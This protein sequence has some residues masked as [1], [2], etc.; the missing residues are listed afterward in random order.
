VSKEDVPIQVRRF[1]DENIMS[2][3]EL[4]TLLLLCSN[5][6]KEWVPIEVSQELYTSIEA[7]KTRLADLRGRGLLKEI[8]EARFIYAPS[9]P[10]VGALVTELAALYKTRR[11]TIITLIYSKPSEQIRAFS[12]AFRIKKNG[13]DKNG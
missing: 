11:V 6:Q 4:E 9:T 3:E 12:D 1:I 8:A 10:Q 5:P 13:E 2:V 7:A